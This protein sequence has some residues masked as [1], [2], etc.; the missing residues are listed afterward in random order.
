MTPVPR[1]PPGPRAGRLAQTVALHRDPLGFL[2]TA[3]A[4]FGDVF[5]IRLATT[6]PVVVLASAEAAQEMPSTDP[7]H[8]CAGAARR[9]VLP[10]ASRLSVFGGDGAEHH[11]ARSR[12]EA[13]FAPARAAGLRDEIADIAE[14]HVA[15]WPKR[16]PFRLLPRM[17]GIADEVSARCVLGIRDDARAL[18]LADA[19][20]SMLHTPGNPPV[21]IPGPDDGLLGP[22]VDAGYRKR[23]ERVARVLRTE[24][25]E[26]RAATSPGE[27][28]LGLVA[29]REPHRATGDLVEELLSLLMAAQEPMAATLTWQAL[30][31]SAHPDG[32]AGFEAKVEEGLRLQPPALGSLRELRL[33]R[34][35]GGHM[36]PAGTST[37]VP[38]PVVQRDPRAYDAPDA[39]RPGRTLD[40]PH[41]PFGGGGRSCI[42][43]PL[44]REQIATVVPIALRRR[45]FGPV[46]GEVEPMVLRAT[47][48][49]PKRSGLVA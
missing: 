49:V 9:G 2:R 44:A 15:S 41:L 16:R 46:G 35:I 5:T 24:V 33:E 12:I 6:G 3:Q 17:R 43:E 29:V 34:E 7:E 21:T 30:L 32:G 28:V 47:I 39:F 45:S 4:R 48:L 10:Q 13:A 11:A 25:D 27:G 38:I 31:H 22:L 42:A 26:R 36:L 8:S 20:G 18:E 14:R 19:V 40:G 37:M 23:R 1:L